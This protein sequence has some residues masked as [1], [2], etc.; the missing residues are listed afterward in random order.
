MLEDVFMAKMSGIP[1]GTDIAFSSHVK[2]DY[3]D[4]DVVMMTAS[5]AG[6]QYWI[7][8][9]GAQDVTTYNM[10]TSYQDCAT[11]RRMFNLRVSPEFETWCQKWDILDKD[12]NLGINAGDASIFL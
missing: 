12:G 2:G 9:P 7:G 3:N 5:L 4:N 10:D 11:L 1:I 6:T 8:V